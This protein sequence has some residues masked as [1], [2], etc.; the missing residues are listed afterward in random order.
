MFGW[1]FSQLEEF[2]PYPSGE[3]IT[4]NYTWTQ[5]DDY[6]IKVIAKDT[7]NLLSEWSK[8]IV[9]IPRNRAT[10][11]SLLLRFLEQFPILQK[12]LCYIL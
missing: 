12:I 5:K 11:N 7:N 4:L 2:G 9:T 1:R 3:E 10:Y 8:L 6:T